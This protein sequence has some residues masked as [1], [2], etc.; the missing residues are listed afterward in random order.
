[1]LIKIVDTERTTV[2]SVSRMQMLQYLIKVNNIS[3]N[4]TDIIQH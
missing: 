1:M 3:T 4:S 2:L